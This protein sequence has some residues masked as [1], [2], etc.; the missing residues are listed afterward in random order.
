MVEIEAT[1][2]ELASLLAQEERFW[3][4]RAKCFWLRHGNSNTHFFHEVASSRKKRN[5]TVKLKDETCYFFDE[6]QELG[7]I[8]KSYFVDLFSESNGTYE[9][10]IEVIEIKVTDAENDSVCRPF[11]ADEFKKVVFQMH[12]DKFSGLDGF[13]PTFY[14]K[15]WHVIGNDIVANCTTWL[16]HSYFSE[17]LN[18]TNIYFIPKCDDPSLMRDLR[19]IAHCNVLY[20]IMSKVI[21]NGLKG[22]FFFCLI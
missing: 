17:A 3:Q 9:P 18:K 22:F 2:S 5:R 12:P 4:R 19:P 11:K 15:F 8:A 6:P 21:T 1:K 7:R 20:K 10:I 16:E 14:M 13:N